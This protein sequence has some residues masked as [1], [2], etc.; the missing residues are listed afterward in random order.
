MG[1]KASVIILRIPAS[2]GGPSVGDVEK[3]PAFNG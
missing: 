3:N 1:V 2:S